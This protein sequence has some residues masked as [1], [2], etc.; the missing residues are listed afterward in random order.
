MADAHSLYDEDFVAWAEQQGEALRSAA[1]AGSNLALDLDHLAEEIEDLGRSI[2]HELRSQLTRI[3]RHLL[4]LQHSPAVNPRRGWRESVR[5]ARMEIAILL[6]ESPSLK[7]ELA[8]FAAEQHP[9]ALKLAAAD[10]DDYEELDP[11][12]DRALRSTS[13]T[14]EQITSD[15]FPTG[16]KGSGERPSARR[17]HC[18]T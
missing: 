3:L 2:R 10:L 13:Y 14:L 5:E 18:R 1:R 8:R 7:Q 4:K 9:Q 11:A 17:A 6:S 16:P 12:R 15:W